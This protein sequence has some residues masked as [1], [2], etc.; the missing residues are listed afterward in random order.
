MTLLD[1]LKKHS[2]DNDDLKS[3]LEKFVS[4]SLSE[5]SGDTIPKDRFKEVIKQKNEA[6][7]KLS[8]IEIELEALKKIDVTAYK[9]ANEKL[10]A[11]NETLKNKFF[12]IEKQSFKSTYDFLTAENE[13]AKKLRETS[14]KDLPSNFDEIKPEQIES[15]KPIIEALK[16]AGVFENQSQNQTNLNKSRTNN[17]TTENKNTYDNMTMQDKFLVLQQKLK[18]NLNG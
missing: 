17:I 16:N 18:E 15:Y 5:K 10:T 8:N 4:D 13:K 12:D 6:I 1:I 11:E 2:I 9:N 14:F 7:E 3:E